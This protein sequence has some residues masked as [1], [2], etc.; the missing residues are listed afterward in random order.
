MSYIKDFMQKYDFPTD[1][2]TFLEESYHTL[3]KHKGAFE[4]FS[5]CVALYENDVPFDFNLISQKIVNLSE[6]TKISGSTLEMLYM[7]SLTPHLRELYARENIPDDIYDD[8]VCDLKWKIKECKDRH[9]I[10]GLRVSWWS[11]GFFR[12]ERFAI[13]RLQFNIGE[14]RNDYL[15][16]GRKFKK[17][18]KY[19][20]VHI[21]SSGPL[22]YDQCQLSYK[23][24]AEF[25]SKRYNLDKIIFGCNS[26]LLAPEN[27]QILPETSNILKFMRDYTILETVPETT[28]V[29]VWRFFYLD[30]VPDDFSTLPDDTS[31]KRA[32]IKW[33]ESGNSYSNGFGIIIFD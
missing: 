25:F 33:L 10:W 9:G 14:F 12:L 8:S 13:G 27:E 32:F 23:R 21:P 24:A 29:V 19:V 30:E 4:V 31:L 16:D 2:I 11:I 17:G 15:L 26:W 18:D 22:D 7:I 3:Q 20:D 28:Q 1:A 5:E 6:V